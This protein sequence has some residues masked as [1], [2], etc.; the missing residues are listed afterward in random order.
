[1]LDMVSLKSMKVKSKLILTSTI[2][3]V[4]ALTGLF[5]SIYYV[6]DLSKGIDRVEGEIVPLINETW[7]IRNNITLIES[8]ILDMILSKDANDISSL[9]SKNAELRES[10]NHSLETIEAIAPS[11]DIEEIKSKIITLGD[12]RK[13][14]EG[15]VNT[16][17]DLSGK[18]GNLFKEKYQPVSSNLK[19]SLM[20]I[21]QSIQD[22]SM[23]AI[24]KEQQIANF[25][26]IIIIILSIIFLGFSILMSRLL[27]KSIIKPLKIINEAAKEMSN[28]NLSHKVEYK[29][30][31]E[32]GELADSIGESIV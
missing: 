30:E 15:S 32:F 24:Q 6:N 20:N 14:I 25:A 26:I 28:G 3:V 13:E 5:T 19:D 10:I 9:K 1:M 12:V 16:K 8:N 18:S 29:S 7:S 2:I 4:F 21:S 23:K 31:D 27:V 22:E 17:N 11:D